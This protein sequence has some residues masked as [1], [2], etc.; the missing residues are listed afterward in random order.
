MQDFALKK[1]W[2]PFVAGA[3]VVGCAGGVGTGTTGS[4]TG[5]TTG[6]T[7]ATG[8]TTSTTT[9]APTRSVPTVNLPSTQA[10]VRVAILSGQGRRIPGSL[11][12]QLNGIRLRI[13]GTDIIPSEFSGSTDGVNV[14]LDGFTTNKYSFAQNLGTSLGKN[15]QFLSMDMTKMFEEQLSGSLSEVFSGAFPINDIPVNVP[16][17]P[18]RESTVQVFL[19]NASLGFDF[20]FGQPTFD[21]SEFNFENGLTGTNR[22]PGFL[23][24]M[25][26][27]D[28][29]GVSTRPALSQGGVADKFML[30]GDALGISRNANFD[31]SFDLF[32]PNFVESGVVTNPVVL[33]DGTAPGT[34][35]VLEPDPSV[36]PPAVVRITALQGS[37]R[38]VNSVVTNLGNSGLLVFPTTRAGEDHMA[39]AYVRSGSTFTQLYF[40][41]ATVTSTGGTVNLWPVSQANLPEGSRSGGFTGTFS[42]LTKVGAVTKDG[43]YTLTGAPS[44]LPATGVFAVYTR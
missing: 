18:G 31:G 25:I 7:T 14:Q 22:I 32:S 15:Y 42:N 34:Y 35:N 11:Y 41:S 9:G 44:G 27:F 1:W 26:A 23:S 37:W 19:N 20:F 12:A 17:I 5:S 16:V 38:N 24:D 36:I 33:P 39:V 3:V 43:D 21:Q 8:G 6:G 40:G 10:D 29:S 30:S 4:T 2:I 13:G 28:I